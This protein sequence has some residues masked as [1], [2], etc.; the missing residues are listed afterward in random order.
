MNC[1]FLVP[2]PTLVFSPD[3]KHFFIDL[4]LDL[5]ISCLQV[6]LLSEQIMYAC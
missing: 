2:R 4:D 3:P 6:S 1:V 5:V